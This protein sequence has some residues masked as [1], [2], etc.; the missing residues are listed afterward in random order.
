MSPWPVRKRI[1]SGLDDGPRRLQLEAVHAGHPHHREHAARRHPASLREK[2]ASPTQRPDRKPARPKQP[3]GGREEG[4][5]S[6]TMGRSVSVTLMRRRSSAIGS[7]KRKA[8]PPPFLFSAHSRPL[9]ASTMVRETRQTDAHAVRLGRDEQVEDPR[10][11]VAGNTMPG[12][13]DGDLDDRAPRAP[14]SCRSHRRAD[15]RASSR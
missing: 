1:G 14:S 6:S 13:A 11:H 3:R 10:Q 5:S 9:C 4:A 8:A 2:V 12:V 7:V 15:P